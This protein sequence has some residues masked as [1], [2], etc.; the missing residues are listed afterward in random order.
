MLDRLAGRGR[1]IF[2]ATHAGVAVEP[3]DKVGARLLLLFQLSS[4]A[5]CSDQ[6]YIN[7]KVQ[8][9]RSKKYVS[10]STQPCDTRS[11]RA[12]LQRYFLADTP[13]TP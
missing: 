2:C 6:R 10:R 12:S 13:T 11:L 4:R 7:P 1:P 9:G 5:D 3:Q 8:G